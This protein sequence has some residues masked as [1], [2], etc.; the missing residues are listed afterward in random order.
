[1]L[2]QVLATIARHNLF[3][4]G[5]RV[6]AAVSGGPDSVC[7]LH[8]LRELVPAQLAGVA[9]FNHKLRGEESED[10]ERF[11]AALAGGFHLP[12]FRASAEV[13]PGNLEQ[14]AR[15]ARQEFFRGLPADRIAL[16][17]TLDDQAE[18]VL[19]RLLRGSGLSGLAGILPVTQE[20]IV[21]PLLDVRRT[22]VRA[23]LEQHRIAWREDSSNRSPQFARNRIRHSLLPQLAKDWNPQIATA[24]AHLADVAYE[25]EAW[26]AQEVARLRV[27]TIEAPGSVEIHTPSLAALPRALLRRLLRQAIHR[28]KGDLR[29]IDYAHVE[30]VATLATAPNGSGRKAIPGLTV[31]RS[32]DWLLLRVPRPKPVLAP[33]PI[34]RAGAYAWPASKSM[35]QLVLD[36]GLH[37]TNACDTLELELRGWRPGDAYCI[38]GAE[39]PTKVKDLFQKAR[40]PSWRR[41]SW[42]MITGKGKILWAKEFGPSAKNSGVSVL[43]ISDSAESF[44]PKPTS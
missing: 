11:V 23:F 25:E 33:I 2:P 41:A 3:P 6:I 38:R 17:H 10:D 18:T 5:T 7:L 28:A 13:G 24:L 42:P 21:R 44:D 43:E 9:H 39:H 32:F 4:L 12:F 29:G 40:V 30:Q 8:V 1:V 22:E 15:R 26:W 37:S 35:I 19:F 34:H 14:N 27:P 31:V 20:G 16:G 36:P